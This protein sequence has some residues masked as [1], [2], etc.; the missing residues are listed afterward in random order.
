M[1]KAFEM[2]PRD[3]RVK[4]ILVNIYG[5]IIR[6]DMVA[7]SIIQAAAQLGPLRCHI[8]VRLQGTHAEEGQ[9]ILKLLAESDFGRAAQRAVEKAKEI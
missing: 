7:E 6:C 3:D 5:G 8:V 2:I 4:V 1:V 9:R